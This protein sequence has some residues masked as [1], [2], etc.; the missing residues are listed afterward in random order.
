M[1]ISLTKWTEEQQKAINIRDKSLLVSAGAGSGKTA[2]LVERIIMIIIEDKIDVRRLLVVTFTKAA[3]EEMRIRIYKA[4]KHK[5][6]EGI[7]G[8]ERDFVNMQLNNL[9]MASISTIHSFC[10]SV[11][12][13]YYHIIGVDAHVRI[14]DESQ[15]AIIKEKAMDS[16]ME[17]EYEKG[18]EKFFYL[19]DAYNNKRTDLPFRKLI[20]KMYSFLIN[21]PFPREWTNEALSRFHMSMEDLDDSIY[22]KQFKENN[23]S[24]LRSAKKHINIAREMANM[25]TNNEGVMKILNEERAQVESLIIALDKGYEEFYRVLMDVNFSTLRVKCDDLELKDSL[26][27]HRNREK[28]IIKKIIE[29]TKYNSPGETIEEINEISSYMDYLIELVFKYNELFSYMKKDKGIMDYN[30]LEHNCIAIL[31]NDKI[32]NELRGFFEFVFVDEYQDSNEIQDTIIQRIK[33]DNNMFF[34]GD[35]KQSIYRFRM[36]DPTLFIN[37]EG[38]FS[39]K[40]R[41]S[42]QE[43]VALNKNFRSIPP[44]VDGINKIFENIM[45]PYVGEVKYDEK[46]KLYPVQEVKSN[47]ARE[48]VEM[49]LVDNDID[50]N[51]SNYEI[52]QLEAEAHCIADKILE[53]TKEQIFDSELNAQR[54]ITYKDMVI[55]LRTTRNRSESYYQV[56]K[57]R[58]IPV[59][60]ESQTGYFETIEI[61]LIVEMLKVIDNR[62]DDIPLLSVLRSPFFNFSVEEIAEISIGK[63][64]SYLYDCI[65]IYIRE[66]V[67]DSLAHKLIEFLRKV[68]S[69][70]KQ[71]TYIPIHE[72]IWKI[73]IESGYQYYI[74]GMPDGEQ[75]VA[76]VLMLV[77][78]AR[79]F[80]ESN[81]K[82]LFNFVKLIEGI[83][84]TKKD[85]STAKTIGSMENTIK[86]MSIHKSK[87]LEFPIVF[88]GD[89]GKGINFQDSRENIIL[90]K[91]LGICPN[92]VNV[93]NRSYNPTFFKSVA[94][95]RLNLETLSEEMRV[96]YV[97]MTRAKEILYLVGSAKKVTDKME[98]TW[99]NPLDEYMVSKANNY[100][101]W[102][103][104]VILQTNDHNIKLTNIRMSQVIGDVEE[105]G[106]YKQGVLA[107]F[108][109][110][111]QYGEISNDIRNKLEWKYPD[112]QGSNIPSK[113]S[114]TD[115]IK[116]ETIDKLKNIRISNT[117]E[118]P[119]FLSKDKTGAQKGTI[120][121]F[122]MQTL[123]LNAIKENYDNLKDEIKNQ[124]NLMIQNE[125]IKKEDV[126][127]YF[128][129]KI[130]LFFLSKLG[131]RMLHSD[132]IF[133]EKPFNLEK[134]IPGED[135][136]SVLIQGVIDC[137]FQ[138]D[139]QYVLVDYKSDYYGNEMEKMI[140]V[141]RYSNQL[142][143]YKEAIENITGRIVKE[144]YL[145]LFY[146]NEIKEISI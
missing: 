107:Y 77:D 132:N 30:D 42:Y 140:L 59:F 48:G 127:G 60:A 1:G 72:L 31:S 93:E 88:I 79:A 114:L 47:H 74:S 28:D 22:M 104:P 145:Y 68:E 25:I 52:S 29:N 87:G 67:H 37:K 128:I 36:A 119:K 122:I 121:H 143:I 76:N 17:G 10:S 141:D 21:R 4:L 11:I 6:K 64:K 66:N 116:G 84:T 117:L 75:R 109:N 105:R 9:S 124:I 13:R 70:K 45:T 63:G 71:S 53:L 129:S 62:Y 8:P 86:I 3:A 33:R 118:T 97:A 130:Q 40:E 57:N 103:I 85:M 46:A 138:E 131:Q 146:K 26:V 20:D 56:L 69:W 134:D 65:K 91:E 94:K 133:R 139:S 61:R 125:L 12:K 115:Y 135:S 120:L 83:H 16:L 95:D 58:G 106:V 23:R 111:E 18:D 92:Y 14:G 99:T 101:D 82:G 49:I 89:M 34:V 51:D 102:I 98:K 96:L 35:V 110:I 7:E 54:N 44:V 2:V 39:S 15:M 43:R 24:G 90:H 112:E 73:L 27:Y 136:S 50:K 32:A 108:N 38:E 78:R 123:D 55:L 81:I 126:E 5:L 137:F 80:S 41:F 113:I 142:M 144:S 100:L 19:L